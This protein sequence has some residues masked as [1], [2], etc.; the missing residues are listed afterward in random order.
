MALS[1]A[2]GEAGLAAVGRLDPTSPNSVELPFPSKDQAREIIVA[3]LDYFRSNEKEKG[4]IK[5]FTEDGIDALLS[6][7]TVHPRATL[8]RAA[9]IV[10]HAVDK[11]ITSI[12]AECVK[13]AA[14]VSTQ[15]T[16]PDV[17]EGIDG[18]I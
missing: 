2:W 18:A 12:D 3:H 1:Q 11:G 9:K 4:S 15:P 5:P 10:Q 7:Q 17:T 14:D 16:M 8:S 6:G 13:A